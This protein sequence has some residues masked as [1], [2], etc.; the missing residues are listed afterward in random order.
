MATAVSKSGPKVHPRSP[1]TAPPTLA[2]NS[3]GGGGAATPAVAG[4]TPSKNAAMAELKSRVLASLAKLSDRDTHHI[5]V[6]DLDRIIRAPPSPDAVP[7]LLNALAS[8]SQGFATPA[9]RELLRLLASLCAAHTEAAAPHLHKVLAHLAK[10]LKDPASD[11]SVRDACRDTAGQLA[12]VYLRPLAASG[13]AEAGNA[14][15]TQFLKP[16][17]EVM[18]EQSKAVQAGAAACL[19]KTVEGAGPGPGVMG[20]FGKL[21]PRVC[22][23]LGGQGMQAKGALLSVIGSLSQVG[24]S[25]LMFDAHTTSLI[26]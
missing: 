7:M 4:A 2:S 26:S 15:V 23:L 6:E 13:A 1:T 17:F 19:A 14:T 25:F 12:A 8:D 18:G 22:K 20:M 10:R 16:L 11:T 9:R 5:A 21:G 3:A 24:A